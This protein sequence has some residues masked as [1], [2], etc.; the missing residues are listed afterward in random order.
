MRHDLVMQPNV[1]IARSGEGNLVGSSFVLGNEPRSAAPVV[2]IHGTGLDRRMWEPLI[3]AFHGSRWCVTYD[4]R[5]YADSAPMPPEPYSTADDLVAV[6]DALGVE[7]AHVVGI[8]RGGRIAIRT[9]IEYP[10]RIRSLFLADPN[11]NGFRSSPEFAA[12]KDEVSEL[13]KSNQV[14]TAKRMWLDSDLFLPARRDPE[15]DKMLH[16]MAERYEPWDWLGQDPET[17]PNPADVERLS[18]ITVPTKV[19]VGELD[20]PHFHHAAKV[21][22]EQVLGASLV[23]LPDVGHLAAIEAPEKATALIRRHLV[24]SENQ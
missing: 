20:L 6:L 17:V 16:N 8:S 4:L 12:I 10:A 19:L 24:E 18:S 9:A 3:E 13:A 5:G 7:S 11:I 14:T 2:F 23:Q 21:I 1:F 22:V 15:L